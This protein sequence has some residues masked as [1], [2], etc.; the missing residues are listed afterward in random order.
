MKVMD[1]MQTNVITVQSDM[2]IKDIARTLFENNIS[3]VPV[4]GSTGKLVG[5]I[6]EGDLLHKETSPRIPD[7]VGV[8][9]ALIYYRGVKQ[10]ESDFKKLI[11]LQASEL[12]TSDVVTIQKDATIEDAAYLMINRGV[13]RLPVVEDGKILGIVTRMDIIKTLIED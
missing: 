11:A 3:G 4:V 9:G 6:S 8:L 10:Y 1:I 13:K 2:E 5:I 7:V 12:M